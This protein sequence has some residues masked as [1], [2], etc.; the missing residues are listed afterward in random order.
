[1]GDVKPLDGSLRDPEKG[2]NRDGG[3]FHVL[4]VIRTMCLRDQIVD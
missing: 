2:Q 4:E 1:M 3:G